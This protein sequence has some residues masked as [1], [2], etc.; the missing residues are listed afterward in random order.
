V[1]FAL[2]LRFTRSTSSSFFLLFFLSIQIESVCKESGVKKFMGNA[3]PQISR[4]SPVPFWESSVYFLSFSPLSFC[5]LPRNG[6][7]RTTVACKLT[8]IGI[9]YPPPLL[10]GMVWPS[11]FPLPPLYFYENAFRSPP[12]LS[13]YLPSSPPPL[14]KALQRASGG[15]LIREKEMW[16]ALPRPLFSSSAERVPPLP[17]LFSLP[18]FLSCSVF[19]TDL[20]SQWSRRI[21]T[22]NLNSIWKQNGFSM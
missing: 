12:F 11:F 19:L 22:E 10:A 1:S 18:F 16:T 14:C 8:Q 20:Q 15:G 9:V 2:S 17:P 4:Y 7:A 3:I 5:C 6:S 21:S 13:P